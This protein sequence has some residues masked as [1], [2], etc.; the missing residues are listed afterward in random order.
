MFAIRPVFCCGAALVRQE[1]RE[2]LDVGGRRGAAAVCGGYETNASSSLT[3]CN[4]CVNIMRPFSY[5]INNWAQPFNQ[6]NSIVRQQCP[7]LC[8]CPETRPKN[9]FKTDD[10]IYQERRHPPSVRRRGALGHDRQVPWPR[11]AA[12]RLPAAPVH[13]SGTA[14][15]TPSVSC[16][17]RACG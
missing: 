9:I 15:H 10:Q 14:S 6:W 4:L 1:V 7:L 2:G 13:L 5:H 12:V 3:C 16:S 8:V 17:C 11:D